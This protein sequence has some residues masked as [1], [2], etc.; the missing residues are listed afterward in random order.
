[1]SSNRKS[2]VKGRKKTWPNRDSNPV[3]LASTLPTAYMP[4]IMTWGKNSQNYSVSQNLA[5]W[6]E[7]LTERKKNLMLNFP[8]VPILRTIT[9]EIM[10]H[11]SQYCSIGIIE[12]KRKPKQV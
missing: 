2:I 11:D 8:K 10:S 1:M 5:Q 4:Y 6:G 3:P 9:V 12:H 7:N